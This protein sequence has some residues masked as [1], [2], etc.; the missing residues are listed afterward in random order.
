MKVV[1]KL[2]STIQILGIFINFYIIRLLQCSKEIMFM[3]SLGKVLGKIRL[4]KYKCKVVVEV[5]V[6]GLLVMGG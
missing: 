1:F 6:S 3:K 4:E 2:Y 5:I